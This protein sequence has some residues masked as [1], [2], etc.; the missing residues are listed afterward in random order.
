ML[1]HTYIFGSNVWTASWC[2][3][4]NRLVIH[5]VLK[6]SIDPALICVLQLI[7]LFSISM[8]VVWAQSKQNGKLKKLF[9][10]QFSPPHNT[11]VPSKN[12][13][14][15]I[16]NWDFNMF[17]A[18]AVHCKPFTS[19]HGGDHCLLCKAS[20]YFCACA[21]CLLLTCIL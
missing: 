6:M 11:F 8:Y 9:Q 13:I 10:V 16:Y 14:W 1:Y 17:T 20:I 15:V 12:Q 2:N 5:D 18:V 4:V 7:M 19:H 21:M 3:C